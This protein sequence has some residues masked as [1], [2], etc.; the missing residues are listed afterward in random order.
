VAGATTAA[1][2]EFTTDRAT[3]RTTTARTTERITELDE[4]WEGT[5]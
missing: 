3:E 4:A 1:S 2:R 5:P